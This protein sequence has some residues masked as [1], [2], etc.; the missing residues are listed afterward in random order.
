MSSSHGVTRQISGF[1]VNFPYQPYPAQMSL[2][3]RMLKALAR[4]CNV[5]LESPTGSGKTM[6]ILCA[7]LAW[8]AHMKSLLLAEKPPASVEE[9]TAPIDI[10]DADPTW[11]DDE[12]GIELLA[13]VRK[14][15][16]GPKRKAKKEP[17]PSSRPPRVP[18]IYYLTRTHGLSWHR[19]VVRELKRSGYN[20]RMC[21]LGS[22][23]HYCINPLVSGRPNKSVE[24]SAPFP[25]RF[26]PKRLLA[27][28][29]CRYHRGA[30]RLAGMPTFTQH[31]WDIEALVSQGKAHW[32][33]PYFA[34]RQLALE[35]ELIICPYNYLLDPKIRAAMAISIKEA[36]LIFD[37]AHREAASYHFDL[38]LLE[39]AARELEPLSAGPA[40]RREPRYE[41]MLSIAG[42]E[43]VS[44]VQ[45][46][47][48]QTAAELSPLKELVGDL[49]AAVRPPPPEQA[50]P[51]QGW[52]PLCPPGMDVPLRVA[53]HPP[54]PPTRRIH[55]P[56]AHLPRVCAGL[57][58]VLLLLM[59]E[60]YRHA[61]G[62]EMVLTKAADW[63]ARD[64]LVPQI[65]IFSLSPAIAFE[66]L[67]AARSVILA[68]GTLP[69]PPRRHPAATPPPPRRHPAATPPPPRR[70][71]AATTGQ[72]LDAEF[73]LQLEAD[74]V[75]G[76]D[77]VWIGAIRNDTRR[78]PIN[79]T[80]GKADQPQVQDGIGETILQLAAAIP[81]GMLC[82]FP[83]Y[84]MLAKFIGR[85]REA[86]IWG[87]LQARKA[88]FVEPQ[89][90]VGDLLGR[91]KAAVDASARATRTATILGNDDPG[92][93]EPPDDGPAT[94]LEDGAMGATHH[95]AAHPKR[96]PAGHLAAAAPKRGRG[97]RAGDDDGEGNAAGGA[98]LFAVCRGKVSEGIDFADEY[99]RGVVVVGIPYP[100]LKSVEVE[101]KRQY[102]DRLLHKPIL[103]APPSAP[104]GPR[105]HECDP[106]R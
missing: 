32:G 28:H 24:W 44:L 25:R 54:H 100:N 102:N 64:V 76:R 99:A 36:V 38:R 77:Q 11:D 16:H 80:H 48:V 39:D 47:G 6:A 10:E 95:P 42:L 103:A 37:E 51:P 106:Y 14:T 87:Q 61:P 5:L 13:D 35:A 45:R 94:S 2:M 30:V 53:P 65:S 41:A 84:G 7:S 20:P 18:Q 23:E 104:G 26:D 74:H 67:R 90:D 83:S 1:S 88:L 62:Y 29:K 4:H 17:K 27:E 69:P 96:P 34:A 60:G 50:E 52:M 78:A 8:Q 98:L 31:C 86:G 3:D 9:E 40:H 73:P 63:R 105:R 57:L 91:F 15:G 19:V 92:L 56:A 82:F 59:T 22:R 81:H 33:C 71:P 55:G 43:F 89:G 66:A 101:L 46:A 85:W 58:N 75:I 97:G 21:I 79:T 12:E 93:E 70:H 68:S 49:S 72:H